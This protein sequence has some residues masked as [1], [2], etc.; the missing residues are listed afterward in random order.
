MAPRMENDKIGK[1]AGVLSFFAALVFLVHPI[2]TQGVTYV[3]QR[4]ASLATFF[5]LATL[6]LY[7]QSWISRRKIY[8]IMSLVTL[9]LAMFTKEIAFTLPLAVVLYEIIFLKQQGRFPWQRVLPFIIAL[10]IIPLIVFIEAKAPP[11]ETLKSLEE[12]A[13]L[14]WRE[15][16][17]TEF[18]VMVTYIR[19]LLLPIRQNLDYDYPIYASLLRLPV[20]ASILFLASLFLAAIR[21]SAKYRLVSFGIF[22]FFLA[23]LVESSVVPITDVIFEHRLYLPM[24]GFSLF[25]STGLYYLIGNKNLK[26]MAV[27]MIL[28]IISYSALAYTRNS[29][30]KDDFV[31]WDDVVHKS[32]RKARGYH[33]RGMAIQASKEGNLLDAIADFNKAIELKAD[34]ASAYS[35]QGRIYQATGDIQKAL[36]YFNKAIQI[37]P[38]SANYYYNRGVIYQYTKDLTQALADYNKA[39]EFNPQLFAAYNNRGNIYNDRSEFDLAIADYSKAIELDKTHPLIYFNRGNVYYTKKDFIKAIADYS[40]AIEINF[41]FAPAYNARAMAYF[42]IKEYYKSWEDV[43]KAQGLGFRVSPGFLVDLEKEL[44]KEE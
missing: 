38:K 27:V 10:A 44:E 12:A 31:L 20:L 7:A 16:L 37:N 30:W 17:F 8:Y 23:L 42:F 1:Q 19:L 9:A 29:V 41:A 35:N 28:I 40:K 3:Y 43:R 24:I 13:L 34:Y 25:L 15:Y 6:V 26:L 2:Q 21:L 11:A 5:Y 36:S 4:T 22:W 33:N 32:P 39:L 18:R 14:D